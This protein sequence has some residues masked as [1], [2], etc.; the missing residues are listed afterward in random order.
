MRSAKKVLSGQ[1]ELT[2]DEVSQLLG[3]VRDAYRD[4]ENV[5]SAGGGPAL[6]VGDLHGDLAAARAVVGLA[7]SLSE[8][9]VVFLGDYGDRGYAQVETFNLVLALAAQEPGR[10]TLLRGNHEDSDIAATY[11]MLHDVQRHY[12]D[13]AFRVYEELF[14]ALPVA[15]ITTH[16]VFACHGGVPQGV[17][18]RDDLQRCNRHTPVI[19]DHVLFELLWNDPVDARFRFSP[20]MRGGGA[21]EFGSIAFD[22]FAAALDIRLMVR[23]HQ[24]FPEGLRLFFGG[25]LVSVFSTAYGGRTVPTVCRVTPS[26]DIIPVPLSTG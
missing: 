21:R 24:A 18:S 1:T 6:Y 8:H 25:R 12:H 23:A 5:V 9:R 3:V 14:A 2:F 16:G 11:G 13:G 10:I 26:L 20:S 4:R 19:E 15:E 17:H 22:E 7:R